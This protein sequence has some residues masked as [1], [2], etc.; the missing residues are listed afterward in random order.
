M[1]AIQADSGRLIVVSNRGPYRFRVHGQRLRAEHTVGGLVSA[2]D[3]L[4][5]STGGTWIAW[6]EGFTEGDRLGERVRVPLDDPAYL[7]SRIQ[8]TKDDVQGY[9]HGFSNRTLWP[10]CHYF[11][12]RCEF[13]RDD[14]ERYREVNSRFAEVAH[15]EAR[16][17][18]T[19][20]I[21]DYHLALVPSLLRRMRTPAHIA[22]FW[23]IPFPSWDT[24]RALPWRSEIIEGMLGADEIGFHVRSYVRHFVTCATL[25]HGAKWNEAAETLEIDGRRIRVRACP[26]GIEFGEFDRIVRQ[27]ATI[28]RARQIRAAIAT[29]IVALGVDRMDYSKGIRERLHGIE[30]FMERYP[31]YHRRFA[32]IQI[33][34]PSR[35]EVSE[36]RK[37]GR[38]VDET[39]G[40][41]NGRFAE[42]GWAPISY[43][44]RSLP[45]QQL[46]A[47]YLAADIAL[48]TPLR[49]GLNLIA[50]EYAA[51]KPDEDGTLILSEFAGA[52]EEMEG[53]LIVNPYN[54]DD[55][56]EKL[57]RALEMPSE[58]RRARMARLRHL[59]SSRDIAWWRDEF[60]GDFLGGRA[61]GEWREVS[62]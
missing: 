40:R 28:A 7:F 51:C 53:V 16:P 62:A 17:G 23:H 54:V 47:Y 10:L 25:L 19:V 11:L 3:P 9:Y 58:E 49:D 36:Y 24:F 1:A 46:A 12:G 50:K 55:V 30:R 5:R 6:D 29:P 32:F 39:V 15:A 20:F 61:P 35:T 57:H 60:L 27:P 13:E 18:D 4:L 31:E 26:L 41:V 48:V 33:A 59:A 37:I 38:A 22:L 52:A 34:V 44:C 45:R 21:Q 14:Y 8:L 56:A 43:F 2:L 42:A